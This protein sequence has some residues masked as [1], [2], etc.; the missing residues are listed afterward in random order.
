VDE[1][2]L[3][4][5][6]TAHDWTEAAR[7]GEEIRRSV[8][9][10]YGLA[11]SVGCGPSKMV[12][13]IASR[14]AKPD[15]M[16]VI[17]PES[18]AGVVHPLSVSTMG[19]VGEKTAAELRLFGIR[20]IGDLAAADPLR[21]RRH[22]GKNGGLL[23]ELARGE[24]DF[25][26]TPFRDSP[27]PKSMSNER[28]LPRDTSDPETIDQALLFLS[29]RL[30][31]RLRAESL[32]GNV[33]HMKIRFGDFRTVMRSRTLFSHTNDEKTLLAL[34]RDGVRRFSGGNAVRLLGIGL[35]GL[36]P[37]HPEGEELDLDRGR[38]SYRS[39]LA[40]FDEVRDRFGEG[41]LKKARLL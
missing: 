38:R 4:L 33:F 3:D 16:R 5:S 35:S 9:K 21:L 37:L 31:R 20:T 17:P 34:A 40:V 39:S 2:Y 13:K 14:L 6:D 1:A 27:D 18:I 24:S 15:G 10:A 22:F 8:R 12:A 25:R 19:G 7:A 32:A 36:A 30:A 23:S 26:V 28:T 11:A 29:E 41:I